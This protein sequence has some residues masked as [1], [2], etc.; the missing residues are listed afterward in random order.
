M[1]SREYR[2]VERMANPH[3]WLMA[4]DNLHEQVLALRKRTGQSFTTLSAD[5]IHTTWDGV[6]RSVFLLGGFALE[7]AIKAFLVYEHP[8]WISNGT[9]SA[10]LRSHSLTGLQKQS[11]LIPYQ[12][13]YVGVL[14]KFEDGL[15]SWA[16]YPCG[17][18]VATSAPEG[19][20]N[21]SLWNGYLRLMSAYGVKLEELLSRALWQGPH[22]FK[23]RWTFEGDTFL[24]AN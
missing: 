17:L 20:L 1:S 15:E 4:A 24:N 2:F 6:N 16:R 21:A 14:Q 12:H 22:G 3:A 11:R 7:N 23:G 13:K 19:Q 18:T 10:R 8:E 9:L 5:G